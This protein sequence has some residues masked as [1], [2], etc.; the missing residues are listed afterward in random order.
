MRCEYVVPEREEHRQIE[1]FEGLFYA[2]PIV[3]EH[4]CAEDALPGRRRCAE[5]M[6][7]VVRAA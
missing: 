3:P 7:R 1:T 4:Q 5:H 2:N 6:P